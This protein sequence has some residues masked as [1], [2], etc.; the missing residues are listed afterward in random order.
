MSADSEASWSEVSG[1]APPAPALPG[2]GADRA[3]LD[4]CRR[5]NFGPAVTALL[6]AAFQPEHEAQERLL[7]ERRSAA[8]AAAERV[9]ALAQQR[10]A[11][12]AEAAAEGAKAEALRQE[13]AGFEGA[14]AAATAR[15]VAASAVAAALE[16]ECAGQRGTLSALQ[17]DEHSLR[18]SLEELRSRQSQLELSCVALQGEADAAERRRTCLLEGAS[19]AEAQVRGGAGAWRAW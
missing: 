18:D 3:A 10:A 16:A 5:G 12:E 8:E 13:Q 6:A 9:Q 14:C 17:A 2:A 15:L 1:P 7:A 4:E 19:E 11:L